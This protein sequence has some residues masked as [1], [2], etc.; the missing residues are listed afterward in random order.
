MSKPG[1]FVFA[2]TLRRMYAG[3]L[4]SQ[5]DDFIELLQEQGYDR[6]S[7]RCKIRSVADFSRWLHRQEWALEDVD[8][9]R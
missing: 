8:P 1:F 6:H 9:D 3:P 5:I 4:G 2:G 7:I